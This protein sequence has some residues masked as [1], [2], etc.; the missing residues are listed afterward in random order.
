MERKFQDNAKTSYL[1]KGQFTDITLLDTCV[2]YVKPLLE[3]QPEIIV[4][5]KTCRQKRNVGFFS[6]E[7]IGYNYSRKTM[8]AKPLNPELSQLL[9]T[10]NT[11]LDADFNGILVNEY[12]DGTQYISAH[13]DDESGLSTVGVA[14]ISYGSERIFRIRDKKN[15]TILHDETTTH[16]SII[17]M[18]GAFQSLYTHEIPVQKKIKTPRISLTFR[19]HLK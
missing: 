12:E 8:K 17:H 10:V 14:S 9:T 16:G 11:L 2:A 4:F 5:N 1:D 15:K 7:S 18:G 3:I 13:S 6:N 19:K